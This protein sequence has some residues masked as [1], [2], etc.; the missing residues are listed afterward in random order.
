[1]SVISFAPG[2]NESPICGKSCSH[3]L[4]SMRRINEPIRLWVLMMPNSIFSGK[5]ENFAARCESPSFIIGPRIAVA[6]LLSARRSHNRYPRFGGLICMTRLIFIFFCHGESALSNFLTSKPPIPSLIKD[7]SLI[8]SRLFNKK[9]ICR[10][11]ASMSLR[12]EG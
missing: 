4:G 11:W 2:K 1:M 10:K 8:P 9:S 12:V 5:R 6:I 7:I 3:D